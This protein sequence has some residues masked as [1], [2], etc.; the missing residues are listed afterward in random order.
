MRQSSSHVFLLYIDVSAHSSCSV[1]SCFDRPSGNVIQIL[2]C[3]SFLLHIVTLELSSSFIV[4]S[5][6]RLPIVTSAQRTCPPASHALSNQRNPSI[7]STTCSQ[8]ATF[9]T[10]ARTA[11]CITN[12]SLFIVSEAAIPPRTRIHSRVL[13]HFRQQGLNFDVSRSGCKIDTSL[14][15][16]PE[17]A[18]KGKVTA[19]L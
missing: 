11:I 13:G 8:L 6:E 17:S 3:F 4:Y 10:F 2:F 5:H 12:H 7:I 15:K 1:S 19:A 9:N 18:G 16:C 14:W